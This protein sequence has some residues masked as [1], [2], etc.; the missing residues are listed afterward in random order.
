MSGTVTMP[1]IQAAIA[2]AQ[3]KFIQTNL[4]SSDATVPA[5]KIDPNLV[6]PWGVA[7]DPA[8]P[9]W[10]S[11]NARG[12][13]TIDSVSGGTI[14]LDYIPPVKIAPA[15]P[16]GIAT[17]TGQ[18]FNPFPNAFVLSNGSAATF[19][20]VDEDGTISGWNGA[21]G[22]TSIITVNESTDPA[23]GDAALALGAVY[24]GLAIGTSATGPTLYAANIRH[25]SVDMFDSTFKPIKNFTDPT[26]PTGYVPFNV[27]VLNGK[28]YVAFAL[29]DVTKDGDVPGLGNGFV[30][31]F[32]LNG[33]M[34]ARVG[35]AGTLNS[36]WGLAIAPKTFGSLAGDLLVGN[37]GDGTINAYDL[38]TNQFAGQLTGVDGKPIAIGDLW[39]LTPGNG[40][41]AGD[42]NTIY[43][44]AGVKEEAQGLFGSL[45]AAP[46]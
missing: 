4:I 35:S 11:D 19:L 24:K 14:T 3:P 1:T 2:P 36:P 41:L 25:G 42:I 29:Q 16:G 32:D 10:I 22:A 38:T 17:P 44:T 13:T 9:F 8:G 5:A 15:T 31:A 43:F 7:F 28:L 33:N 45:I 34:L 21:A 12:V 20:F 26:L 30:D 18:V 40:G 46:S 6:N 39:A 37:F 23:A 27:Q